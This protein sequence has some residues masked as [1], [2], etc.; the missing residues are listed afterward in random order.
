MITDT[1]WMLLQKRLEAIEGSL[2]V[3][4][5]YVDANLKQKYYGESSPYTLSSGSLTDAGLKQEWGNKDET[6]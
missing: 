4:E 5:A 1:D 3:L 6:N 2:R